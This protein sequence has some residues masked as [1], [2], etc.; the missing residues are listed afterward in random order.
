MKLSQAF[1][2]SMTFGDAQFLIGIVLLQYGG[3]DTYA[4]QIIAYKTVK[5]VETN[6]LNQQAVI[7][8]RNR[9]I[10]DIKSKSKG[11]FLKGVITYFYTN[12]VL[13]TRAGSTRR[14]SDKYVSLQDVLKN[15][16][17]EKLYSDCCKELLS[18]SPCDF[19]A[20]YSR[21][22]VARKIIR[23]EVSKLL[24]NSGRNN[25]TR[26]DE[27][28]IAEIQEN[29]SNLALTTT[30]SSAYNAATGT[31][32]AWL[33][34]CF[35]YYI[36]SSGR[37]DKGYDLYK[38]LNTRGF[39]MEE[40]ED[41]DTFLELLSITDDKEEVQIDFSRTMSA[42][43][44][45][46]AIMYRP[47]N[48]A[49]SY[50][51]IF[52]AYRD[53]LIAKSLP[54]IKEDLRRCCQFW[55]VVVQ[56]GYESGGETATKNTIDEKSS[57]RKEQHAFLSRIVTDGLKREN[58]F[59]FIE[60]FSAMDMQFENA[61]HVSSLLAY[62]KGK[63][64]NENNSQVMEIL[65]NG[66]LELKNLIDFI[67]SSSNHYGLTINN[68]RT[69]IFRDS[70][71]LRRFD[72]MGNYFLYVDEVVGLID[73]VKYDPNYQ[74]REQKLGGIIG[75]NDWLYEFLERN[76]GN[77]FLPELYKKQLSCSKSIT[78][79]TQQK[80]DEVAANNEIFM[81]FIKYFK[82]MSASIYTRE[83]LRERNGF[84]C[85]RMLPTIVN[86]IAI[87]CG[88]L[89]NCGE[90]D[91]GR[92]FAALQMYIA[93]CNLSNCLQIITETFGVSFY[94][95]K[96]D[97]FYCTQENCLVDI[98]RSIQ[99][100]ISCTQNVVLDESSNRNIEWYM[101]MLVYYLDI[102]DDYL[103]N[104]DCS[105]NRPYPSVFDSERLRQFFALTALFESYFIQLFKVSSSLR[106]D[107][108]YVNSAC[109][110]AHSSVLI[111]S[112]E[113]TSM[114][115]LT[116]I[117]NNGPRLYLRAD[118]SDEDIEKY[119]IPAQ[120]D[121]LMCYNVFAKR[122][123]YLVRKFKRIESMSDTI[124][125]TG[126]GNSNS[127]IRLESRLSAANASIRSI[128][129][130]SS[131]RL[132]VRM[133][134]RSIFEF[135][136]DNGFAMYGNKYFTN[137]FGYVHEDGYL[138]QFSDNVDNPLKITPIDESMIGSLARCVKEVE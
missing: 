125:K 6:V 116:N 76:L 103:H 104:R 84:V 79:A 133:Q 67:N 97:T 52:S 106:G 64:R 15:V 53:S 9:I 114:D 102:A 49:K 73:E 26:P 128:G 7:D 109:F 72:D 38:I 137:V 63:Q 62:N 120:E 14:V 124:I 131:E 20:L 118:V 65:I 40:T 94:N 123:A 59:K 127:K 66:F 85:I 121:T 55:Q 48:T 51:D 12:N 71:L 68:F 25:D 47:Q 113:A 112:V 33:R 132:R 35:V 1:K 87:A 34:H 24:R 13:L 110:A 77:N 90:E 96:T 46:S 119:D 17:L 99:N 57:A 61:A 74:R 16:T 39:E 42:I 30:Y 101:R 134:L 10:A 81:Y 45:A 107:S 75:D 95:E 108:C 100:A 82:P 80:L 91:E 58:V 2:E 93:A 41:G 105:L 5:D 89:D 36:E 44:E 11:V 86:G 60:E 117:Y 50:S 88:R 129:D 83:Q 78:S 98:E 115:A 130:Y 37:K 138:V 22:K 3:Y 27:G 4:N 28:L 23:D 18:Y 54:K 29:F 70:K 122:I 111:T 31:P 21:T 32:G 135:S 126:S 92:M 56:S 43:C 136:K 19:F 8:E 69:D